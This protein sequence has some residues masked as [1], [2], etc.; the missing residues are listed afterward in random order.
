MKKV[1][2]DIGKTLCCP[3]MLL[4]NLGE[5]F[6]L[7][8]LNKRE[9]T[10]DWNRVWFRTKSGNLY[11]VGGGKVLSLREALRGRLEGF[12]LSS[13][14]PGIVE[15]GSPF[16]TRSVAPIE[17]TQVQKIIISRG[18]YYSRETL[19]NMGFHYEEIPRVFLEKI[20]SRSA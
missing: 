11:Y 17:T 1:C 20:Q 10:L 18:E 15:V 5:S 6:D 16:D 14:R 4:E 7:R 12:P 2:V 19:E 13:R 9:I 8:E 3:G